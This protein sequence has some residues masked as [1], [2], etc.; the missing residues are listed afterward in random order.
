MIL[1]DKIINERKRN[2]WSQEE[3]AEMLSVSRQSVSKWEGAQA[4][5]DLQKI[6]KLAELFNVST[7][8]LL[9]DEIEGE[10]VR[11]RGYEADAEYNVRKVTLE[12]ANVYLDSVR[13]TAPKIAVGVFMC[14]V[15][16]VV[17]L[18]MLAVST[19]GLIDSTVAVALGLFGLFLLIGG[20]VWLFIL[21]GSKAEK[22][23][24]IVKAPFETAYGV[25]GMVKERQ[26]AS[27]ELSTKLM[28][29]AVLLCVFSPLPI[30]LAAV[31]SSSGTLVLFMVCL[32]LAMIGLAVFLFV[33]VGSV[34]DSYKILLHEKDS[35]AV[36][37]EGNKREDS[38]LGAFAGAYWM[39][40]TAFFLAWGFL[41]DAWGRNWVIWPV[42]GVLFAAVMIILKA[43]IQNKEK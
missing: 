24:L 43:A 40:T 37:N 11:D 16:P 2:G 22:N 4:V 35:P 1:A 13:E 25:D 19:A 7:D 10:P 5:P 42:A 28:V 9:K 17:L 31:L 6:L 41:F 33:I 38:I 20:A 39:I 8:Y 30:I 26:A 29:L 32:L 23:N 18:A 34:T 14:V 15:S 12:E 27:S 36:Q 3:L 21:Y